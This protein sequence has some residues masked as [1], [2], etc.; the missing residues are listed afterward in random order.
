MCHPRHILV[1]SCLVQRPDNT[2]LAVRHRRRGWELPQG[3]VEEG[4]ALL[5]A[6]HREVREETGVRLSSPKI[7][8]VWSK[9]SEP[10]ALIHGF[11]ADYATGLLTPSVET[12]EVAWLTV[13]EARQRFTH[14][15]NRDRLNDLL[16][17]RDTVLFSAYQ[18]GPYRRPADEPT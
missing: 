14:P 8:A 17:F 7:A 1:V 4:E 6:L 10:V 12:P 11:V 5:T 3:R 9:L 13:D 18:T 16:A 2:L 15:V